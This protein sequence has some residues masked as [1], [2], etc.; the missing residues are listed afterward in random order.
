MKGVLSATT[1][2]A[3]IVLLIGGVLAIW[4]A[5]TLTMSPQELEAQQEPQG[6]V[7]NEAELT[8]ARAAW[9]SSAHAETYDE[10][11]GANT[12]CARCK[13]PRNWDPTQELAQ[14]QAMDCASCKRVPG[15]PRPALQAGVAVPQSEWRNITCDVCHIPA[16]DSF[17]TGLS[18]W[19]QEKGQYEL[20][21]EVEELCAHCHEGR[22]GFQVQEEQAA[23]QAHTGLSCTDC[24]GSH[25]N[26]SECTDCH[27][28]RTGPGA[29][30]H[31]R[32]PDVNCSGCHDAGGLSIWLETDPGSPHLGEYI[33]VRFAHTLTSWPSHNLSTEIDCERCH[34]PLGDRQAVLV[35]YVSCD[36][37]HEHEFGAV[38]LW[39]T[40]FRRDADPRLASPGVGMSGP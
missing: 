31:H 21:T 5:T 6:H 16:G 34:H 8:A 7:A 30:E 11:M 10:G 12:T 22:H 26:R 2:H 24:H 15:A 25:G 40:F 3:V 17:Y 9:S 33:T 37:C 39:C 35:P 38:S 19:N 18:F 32:H 28:P 4:L 1:K 29:S 23:S 27:D 36:G 13:S 14:T 20:V